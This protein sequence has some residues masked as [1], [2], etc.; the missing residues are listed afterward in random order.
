M[1]IWFQSNM[2]AGDHPGLDI[3]LHNALVQASCKI[4]TEV[5]NVL[6]PTPMPG[7]KHY[8]FTLKDL[9]TCFQVGGINIY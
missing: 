3:E 7:R 5:K 6:R 4:L 1:N 9:V 8:F 2:M